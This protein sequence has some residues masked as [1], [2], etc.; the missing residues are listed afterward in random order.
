[1]LEDIG[2]RG[3]CIEGHP[4]LYKYAQR[5]RPLC[6]N[7]NAAVSAWAREV[8]YV[9]TNEPPLSLCVCLCPQ[10]TTCLPSSGTCTPTRFQGQG[11]GR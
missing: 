11:Q 6:L 4:L 2:W 10:L 7:V 1:M 9:Y 5:N 3:V 8:E